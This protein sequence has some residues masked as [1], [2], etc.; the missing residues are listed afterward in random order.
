[1]RQII[2]KNYTNEG[3]ELVVGEPSCNQQLILLLNYHDINLFLQIHHLQ[4]ALVRSDFIE[5]PTSKSGESFPTRIKD[6]EERVFGCYASPS[7]HIESG[8]AILTLNIS[9][10][11]V[12]FVVFPEDFQEIEDYYRTPLEEYSQNNVLNGIY[13]RDYTQS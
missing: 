6:K 4:Q 8:I 12:A 9:G 7:I 13:W 10:T 1:M 3:L 2:G 5:N 11:S